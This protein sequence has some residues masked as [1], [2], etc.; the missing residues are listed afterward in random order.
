MRTLSR[1]LACLAALAGLAAV[2]LATE[3][4][5]WTHSVTPDPVRGGSLGVA[6]IAT[7]EATLAVR[8][9]SRSALTEVRLFYDGAGDVETVRWRFGTSRARTARWLPSPNSRSLVVPPVL[10]DEFMRLLKVRR[11]LELE[12]ISPD[13]NTTALTLPLNESAVAIYHALVPC[14]G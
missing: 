11:Q 4:D 12:L 3:P 9:T 10:Q 7:P 14:G 5:R 13:G 6:Q 1:V 2:A 8:C